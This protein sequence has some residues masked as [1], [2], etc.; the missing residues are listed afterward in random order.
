[1][2]KNIQIDQNLID[3]I[4]S[5]SKN[6]H[7]IQKKLLKY[8]ANLGHVK[9]LQISILQANF[10]QFLIKTNNYR[11]CLEI[12]TFTGYSTL[13]M[14]LALPSNGK[15]YAIDKDP[16]TNNIAIKFFKEAKVFKKIETEINNGIDAIKSLKKNNRKFDL[17]LIDADKESYI[18][19][20]NYSIKLL[21][22]NGLILF[23]NTLWKGEVANPK[24]LDN[25]TI[26]L[27]KFNNYVK[28]FNINK[29]IL[30]LGDGF[31]I[32]WK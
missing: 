13:S 23:D 16:K 31:T 17:I 8:N 3:Y 7:P 27:K 29:Y 22:K 25:L 10:I 5:H 18:D 32:C 26:K 6:L 4:F 28:K 19:Y 11:S 12:G 14:A 1:M 20:F 9:K 21:N 2:D 30:P 15:I 24:A